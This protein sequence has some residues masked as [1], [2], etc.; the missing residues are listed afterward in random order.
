M[1]TSKK[2]IFTSKNFP[3]GNEVSQFSQPQPS[4]IGKEP[5]LILS[6]HPVTWTSQLG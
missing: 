4:L 3:L 1:K 5:I 2:T 6:I